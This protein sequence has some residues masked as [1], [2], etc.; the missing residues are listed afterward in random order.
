MGQPSSEGIVGCCG[1]LIQG[2][3][4]LSSFCETQTFIQ[5][6]DNFRLIAVFNWASLSLDKCGQASP[7]GRR[8]ARTSKI[9]VGGCGSTKQ[10]CPHLSWV[11]AGVQY[12]I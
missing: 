4:I 5:H 11:I 3:P 12:V 6:A 2:C 10:A 9:V 8:E 7:K 1:S